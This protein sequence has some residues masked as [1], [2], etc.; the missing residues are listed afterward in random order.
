MEF[1]DDIVFFLFINKGY[2]TH[3]VLDIQPN[4]LWQECNTHGLF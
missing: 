2:I 4:V 1:F 3:L